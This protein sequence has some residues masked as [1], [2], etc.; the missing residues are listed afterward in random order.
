M[1]QFKCYLHA[2]F[3]LGT[4]FALCEHLRFLEWICFCCFQI[5][6]SFTRSVFFQLSLCR[7]MFASRVQRICALTFG[8]RDYSTF[9]NG[10]SGDVDVIVSIILDVFRSV[11]RITRFPFTK[12]FSHL[13]ASI[14]TQHTYRVE[15]VAI[16]LK[17]LSNIQCVVPCI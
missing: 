4:E 9:Q 17:R 1:W 16:N 15:L 14:R 6:H 5:V 3:R 10:G 2:L 12:L 7:C 13:L 11:Q 8:S